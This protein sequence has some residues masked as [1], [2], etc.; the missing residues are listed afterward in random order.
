MDQRMFDHLALR[1]ASGL[2]RRHLVRGV[3]AFGL[4]AVSAIGAPPVASA[5]KSKAVKKCKKKL[6]KCC[7][8]G[9]AFLQGRCMTTCASVSTT[10]SNPCPGGGVCANVVN[11]ADTDLINGTAACVVPQSGT[12]CTPFGVPNCDTPCPSGRVCAHVWCDDFDFSCL[13]PA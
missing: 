13:L 9:Q 4:G 8:P 2:G 5:A 6:K 10:G 7:P 3:P 11:L 12:T 1:L